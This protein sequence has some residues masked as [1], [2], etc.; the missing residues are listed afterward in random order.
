MDKPSGPPLQLSAAMVNI[1]LACSQTNG[2]AAVAVL[3]NRAAGS[4]NTRRAST[5]RSLRRLWRLGLVELENQ[6]GCSLTE[7]LRSRMEELAHHE[8]D[9]EAAFEAARTGAAFFPFADAGEYLSWHRSR[10][11]NRSKYQRAQIVRLTPLGWETARRLS[12]R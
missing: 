10:V 4:L 1:L 12:P 9:A 6:Y 2:T 11:E 7:R 5:S 3:V 8:A